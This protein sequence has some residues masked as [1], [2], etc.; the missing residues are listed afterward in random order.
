MTYTKR[1][2]PIAVLLVLGACNK[3]KPV[4]LGCIPSDLA[5]AVI[6]YYPF[7]DGSLLDYSGREHHLTNIGG[8]VAAADRDGNATCAYEFDNLPTASQFLVHNNPS[9]L[10]GLR[11]FS[12]SLWYMPIDPSRDGGLYETLIARDSLQQAPDRSG[13]WAIGLYDCRK[14]T[15]GRTNSV[16]QDGPSGTC[17]EII[18]ANTEIWKHIVVTCNTID[19]TSKMYLDGHL[20]ESQSGNSGSYTAPEIGDL[21]LGR[22]FTGRLDDVIIFNSVLSKSEV[23]DLFKTVP[24]CP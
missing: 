5:P 22:N 2:F 24:C 23:K 4:E 15:F 19:E 14:A 12:I 8:A 13:Q 1:I 18:A 7:S 21:F 10:N 3:N 17:E 9:F 16:W 20:Q 11:E 6:A